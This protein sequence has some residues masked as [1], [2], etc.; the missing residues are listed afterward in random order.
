MGTNILAILSLNFILGN[1]ILKLLKLFT[2][3]GK[4]TKQY[5]YFLFVLFFSLF[6]M[7]IEIS[8]K[9]LF[10]K[11]IPR[12]VSYGVYMRNAY[13]TNNGLKIEDFHSNK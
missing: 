13:R 2:N 5:A 6:F 7:L 9:I 8:T 3:I 12:A 10:S 4:T 11:G 1:A